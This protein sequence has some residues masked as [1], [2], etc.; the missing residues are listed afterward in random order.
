MPN[1]AYFH[2]F[3][4][5]ISAA[6]LGV[7][8]SGPHRGVGFERFT[9]YTTVDRPKMVSWLRWLALDEGYCSLAV[10]M[11]TSVLLGGMGATKVRL[12]SETARIL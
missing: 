8:N 9:L 3:P 6:R 5:Y 11:A 7:E 4:S 12:T 10:G 2:H 1:L